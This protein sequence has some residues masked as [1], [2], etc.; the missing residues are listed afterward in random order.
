MMQYE[1]FISGSV[2]FAIFMF[3]RQKQIGRHII[4]NAR[5]QMKAIWYGSV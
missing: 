1:L 4:E 2:I 3:V 5:Q